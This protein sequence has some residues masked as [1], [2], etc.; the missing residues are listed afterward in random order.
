MTGAR[1][2]REMLT[3]GHSNHDERGFLELLRG[4]EVEAVA[5]VRANARSR[6]PHFN[7]AALEASLQAAGIDYVELGEELGGR[8]QPLAGSP[9]DAWEADAF[10]GYADHM[11]SDEFAAGLARLIELGSTECTAVMCAEADWR[12][13][14]RRLVSDALVVRGWTVDHL[15]RDGGIERHELTSSARVQPELRIIYPRQQT[16]LEV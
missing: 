7:R 10:R 1:R 16:S 2:G 6:H 9:N 12:R 11:A 5:D 15:L 4:A 14:H 13:C 3:V 8:R